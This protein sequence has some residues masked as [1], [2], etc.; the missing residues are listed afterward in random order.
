MF[1]QFKNVQKSYASHK[2]PY[3]YKTT[4]KNEVYLLTYIEHS[5]G[6]QGL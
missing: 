6:I 4:A 1:S 3:Y 5:A 2:I